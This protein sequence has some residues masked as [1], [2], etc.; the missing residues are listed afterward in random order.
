MGK[1]G[2]NAVFYVTMLV[3]FGLLMYLIIIRGEAQ[4]IDSAVA[5][6]A[7]VP[8]NLLEGFGVFNDLLMHHIQSDLGILL[9]QII[10]ILVTC[11]IFGLSLIH[12]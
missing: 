10:V 3:I 8:S 6:S 4:Q 1:S 2:K 12:I 5:T 11:R 7:H 9:L